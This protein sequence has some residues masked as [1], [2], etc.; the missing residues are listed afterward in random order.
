MTPEELWRIRAS[1]ATTA[2]AILA[3]EQIDRERS[4]DRVKRKRRRR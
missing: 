3:V 2:I 1:L 4:T